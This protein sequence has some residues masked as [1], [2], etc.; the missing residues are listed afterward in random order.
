LWPLLTSGRCSEVIN[1][2][3]VP[4]W[5]QNVDR[6]RQVVAFRMLSLAQVWLYMCLCVCAF[7]FIQ[8]LNWKKKNIGKNLKGT[9]SRKVQKRWKE[10]SILNFFSKC[11]F[12]FYWLR[13]CSP[14][15]L[16]SPISWFFNTLIQWF[17]NFS[18]SRTT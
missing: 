18:G 2:I 6:Y 4:I 10:K 5:E 12:F 3:K 15:K 8:P 1:V 11:Y 16:V 9:K 7:V 14:V 13:K 17:P